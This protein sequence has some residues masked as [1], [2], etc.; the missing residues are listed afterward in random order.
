MNENFKKCCLSKNIYFVSFISGHVLGR[1]VAV[2]FD[3]VFELFLA[4]LRMPFRP[5]LN[6]RNSHALFTFDNVRIIIL[7]HQQ[8][9]LSGYKSK[10][11][12]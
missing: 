11:Q 2:F 9:V 3:S 4:P 6:L 12:I 1:S 8:N 10:F 5:G 7:A